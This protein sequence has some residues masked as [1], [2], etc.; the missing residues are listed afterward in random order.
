[1]IRIKLIDE[2]IDEEEKL[3]QANKVRKTLKWLRQNGGV[4]GPNIWKVRDSI[5]GK[6]EEIGAAIADES[7]KLLEE[8]DIIL[9]RYKQYFQDFLTRQEPQDEDRQRLKKTCSRSSAS[10][11]KSPRLLSH[12]R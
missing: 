4:N 12:Q 5:K 10:F 8:E 9:N 11:L 1:M 7:G 2:H 6:K 3:N